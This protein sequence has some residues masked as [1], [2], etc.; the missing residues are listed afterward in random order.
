[1]NGAL[2]TPDMIAERGVTAEVAVPEYDWKRQEGWGRNVPVA[3]KATS[4]SVQTFNG[5][6]QPTDARSDHND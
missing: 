2:L 6:D 4:N 5:K 1:M 3:G